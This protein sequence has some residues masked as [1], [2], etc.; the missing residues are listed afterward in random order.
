[1]GKLIE[2]ANILSSLKNDVDFRVEVT[3]AVLESAKKATY[4]G[5]DLLNSD[6]PSLTMD[7]IVKK[8]E[9]MAGE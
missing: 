8:L 3:D 6:I 5:R 4:K 1:M 9:K 7:V 2:D